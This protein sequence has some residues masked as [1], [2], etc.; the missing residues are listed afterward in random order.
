MIKEEISI[1]GCI[2]LY[3]PQMRN[4]YYIIEQK[5]DDIHGFVSLDEGAFVFFIQ[6]HQENA[7][8]LELENYHEII[9][10]I[11]NCIHK[12]WQLDYEMKVDIPKFNNLL[13]WQLC[14]KLPIKG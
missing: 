11:S 5:L 13:K 1:T 14:S 10:F 7:I 3:N 8:K 6:P 4:H 9:H 12:G 2:Q